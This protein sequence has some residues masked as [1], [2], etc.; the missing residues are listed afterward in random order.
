M[1]L[2]KS[3]LL[4]LLLWPLSILYGLAISLRNLAYR[5]GV[6]RTERVPSFVISIGNLQV[7][8]TGKTPMTLLLADYLT[9]CGYRVA[10][11]SRGYGRR[12]R[13]PLLVSRGGGPQCDVR[14]SGDEAYMMALRSSRIPVFVDRDRVRGAWLLWEMFRPDVIVLDDGFQHRRLY[15]DLDIVLFDPEWVV[16]NCM[17]LPAGPMRE[18]LQAARRADLICF[19]STE[20]NARQPAEK[21]QRLV[22][23]KATCPIIHAQKSVSHLWDARANRDLPIA[24]LDTKKVFAFSGI[25]NSTTFYQMLKH[26]GARVVYWQSFPDH[27]GYGPAIARRLQSLF[28]AS[29]ADVC[30]TTLKDW[31]KLQPDWIF[32]KK[33]IWILEIEIEIAPA[34]LASIGQKLRERLMKSSVTIT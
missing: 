27:K 14:D 25:A 10:I 26:F 12:S 6:L 29:S 33:P 34:F 1:R 21:A 16:T 11:L 30:V 15:R 20:E 13:A 3:R 8:G 22:Q 32:L 23:R 28:E 7:G 5:L 18:P 24:E 4:R 9:E 17:L 19:V 31:V 2:F